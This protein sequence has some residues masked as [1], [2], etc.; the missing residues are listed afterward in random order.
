MARNRKEAGVKNRSAG[1]SA[2]SSTAG[3]PLAKRTLWLITVFLVLV[4]T[5]IILTSL[6]RTKPS[7]LLIFTLDTVRADRLGCYGYSLL[8]SPNI[9][10]LAA[11]GIVFD[12]AYAAAP[13]TLPSH[14]TLFTGLYPPSH[15]VRDNTSYRLSDRALTLAEILKARGYRTGAIVGSFVLDSM[16]GLDQGFMSYDDQLADSTAL[17]E[18]SEFPSRGDIV[19]LRTISERPASAVTDRAVSWLNQNKDENFF[20]WVHYFDAHYPY[21]PPPAI[22]AR[23][24]DSPYD[25]EIAYVDENVG[26]ILSVVE[27][28]GLLDETLIVVTGDH[29]EGLGDHGENTHSVLIYDSTIRV[30]LIV[31]YPKKLPRGKRIDKPVTLADVLPTVLE[32]LGVEVPPGLD[33]VSLTGVMDGSLEKGRVIYSETMFP[34]L[35]YGWSKEQS[36]R[37]SRWKYILST[38]PELYRIDEDRFENRNLFQ[39]EPEVAARYDSLLGS[40]LQDDASGDTGLAEDAGLSTNDRERLLAL[41]YVSSNPPPEGKASLKDPKEMIQFHELISRGYETMDRGEVAEALDIFQRVIDGDPGNVTAL[42]LSGIL[43][44]QRGDTVRSEKAFRKV[45]EINPDFA[46]AHYNLGNIAVSRSDYS[47]AVSYYQEAVRLNPWSRI[48]CIALARAYAALGDDHKSKETWER[49]IELGYS[50]PSVLL[51]YGSSLYRLGL[52]LAAEEQIKKAVGIDP[53]NPKAH[54]LLGN[55]YLSMGNGPQARHHLRKF[56][57]LGPTDPVLEQ[58]ARRL[59]GGGAD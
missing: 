17:P 44:I 24:P 9:D 16:Y 18:H 59:L 43:S 5:G 37:D 19:K 55:L 32:I 39:E 49:V 29:G 47:A 35:N 8:E 54:Y 33:G 10:L 4:G 12:E 13:I 14:T 42:N 3:R 30:P 26:R 53:A 27:A 52:Y 40:K 2:D 28:A 6:R 34:Y 7:N 21:A 25:G 1:K 22:R 56:L 46:N 41:G 45:I 57:D 15:G 51:E 31:H 20:L 50:S 58:N 48:Y 23:Y 11:N 38:N 36:I